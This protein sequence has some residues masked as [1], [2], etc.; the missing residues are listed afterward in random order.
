MI[1]LRYYI[2]IKLFCNYQD[3]I[4]LLRYYAFIK[5]KIIKNSENILQSD[6]VA[7]C[8]EDGDKRNTRPKSQLPVEVVRLISSSLDIINN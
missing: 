7:G 2:I 5:K 4:Q 1:L 6:K 8:H 3:I